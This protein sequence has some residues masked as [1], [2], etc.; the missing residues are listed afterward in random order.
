M[1]SVVAGEIFVRVLH[2]SLSNRVSS[3]YFSSCVL[4]SSNNVDVDFRR[5]IQSLRVSM[6][7]NAGQQRALR[8]PEAMMFCEQEPA[9]GFVS[10]FLSGHR[11]YVVYE[12]ASSYTLFGSCSWLKLDHEVAIFDSVFVCAGSYQISRDTVSGICC[13]E[14]VRYGFEH[15]IAWNWRGIL[16]EIAGCVNGRD[17]RASG[18]TALSPPCWDLLALMH[19]VVNYHST[20][21]GNDRY[22]RFTAG[23]GFNPAGGSPGGS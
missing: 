10:V 19:R 11:N 6:F 22:P 15:V 8:D 2:Q 7:C 17:V 14:A 9:V 1:L 16:C 20:S 21:V 18:N 13:A 3:W 4:V 5:L 23:H 12:G